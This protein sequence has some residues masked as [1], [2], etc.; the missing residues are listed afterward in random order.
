M[1]CINVMFIK[2]IKVNNQLSF[3]THVFIFTGGL[4][5]SVAIIMNAENH[6]FD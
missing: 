4:L 1:I 5:V 3:Y 6:H 2:F